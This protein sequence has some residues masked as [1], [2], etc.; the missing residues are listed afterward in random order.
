M[1]KK[2]KNGRK[3]MITVMLEKD[4]IKYLDRKIQKGI[5]NRESRCAIFRYLVR[6]AMENTLLR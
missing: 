2:K 3:I 1:G 5:K 6:N 4:E